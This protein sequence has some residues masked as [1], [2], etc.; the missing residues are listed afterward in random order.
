[1]SSSTA[2]SPRYPHEREGDVALKD[3]S[4]VRVRP[5]RADDEPAIRAFLEGLSPESIAFRFFGMPN[6][7]WVIAWSIKV[8]YADHFAL[9]AETGTPREIVAHAG[10]VRID[11]D[12]AEVAFVVAD[13]WQGKGISTIMLAHLADAAQQQRISTFFAEVLPANHR[14]LDVFRESGFPLDIRSTPDAIAI[15]FPTSLSPEAVERFEE[16]GRIAAI[17]AVRSFL[18]PRSVAVV[19]A[20]RERGTIGAE[21]LHNLITGE[22]NGAVYAVND[23]A[24]VVQSLPAYRSVTDIPGT[25]ELAVIAVPAPAVVAAARNCAE[26]GVRALLVISAGFAETGEAGER[27][28]RELM[29]ICRDAGIRVVGPNCLGALNT[30]RDVQLNA[31]LAPHAATP[32]RVGFVSESG[33]LGVALIEAADK[34]GIGLSSFVSV[35]NK[36]D[37]SSNDFLQYWEEDPGTDVALLYLE[38]FSQPRKFARI[39]P[40]FARRKPLLAVKSGRSVAGARASSSRTGALVSSSDLTVD[41]LFEQAGVI[42]TD[43]LHD[44]LGVAALLTMQPVPA[45]DRVAIVTSAG[46]PG[47][48]CADACHAAGVEVPELPAHVQA[49]LAEFLACTASFGNP[50]DLVASDS[51]ADYARTIRTLLDARVCDAIV[52]IF[53]SSF[54]TEAAHVATALRE[55]AA[56][57]SGVPIAAVFMTSEGAPAE[58]S[59]DDVQVPCYAFPEDAARAVALAAKYGRWRARPERTVT[60]P[61]GVRLHEAAA[62]I[63]TQLARGAGWLPPDSVAKLLDCYGLPLMPARRVVPDAEEAVALAAELG[64]PVAIRAAGGGLGQTADGGAVR[65]RVAGEAAVR[66]AVAEIEAAAGRA[67]HV[68]N[69][70]IVQP[71]PSSGVELIVGVVNDP[72]FGPVLACGAG[73]TAAKLFTDVAIRITPVTELEASEML[74]SLRTFRLLTGDERSPRYDVAAIEDVLLRVNAMVEA[75]P[76]IAELD[77]NPVIAL[78]GGVLIVDARV[79]IEPAPRQ[80]PM[81]ALRR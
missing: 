12:R 41:A 23:H 63:S 1:M 76:E 35:G 9:V 53:V 37:L 28:Q 40:W 31:T 3:G 18:E 77:C 33:G 8:D 25:V 20:S 52:A 81:F 45:G 7:D 6:L 58:L 14:M 74:R 75:H 46:G 65:Y 56:S 78:P 69:G 13:Q 62:I 57:Q 67:G 61:A 2:T 68:V 39:A 47:I 73:G 16:R 15:E 48:L 11:A 22:F 79:R 72:S 59:N 71:M 50:V 34:L 4:T 32:G 10:Y 17:A 27:S 70:L 51:A 24:D 43:T 54:T 49:K 19:G 42:R 55:L 36:A 5:V 44:L 66:A 64:S 60:T 30:A 21:I 80:R 38:S 29:E 26:A